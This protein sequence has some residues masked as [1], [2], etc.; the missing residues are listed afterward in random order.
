MET[1]TAILVSGAPRSFQ[2]NLWPFIKSL[3]PNFAFFFSF[4]HEGDTK[5]KNK[6]L[7]YEIILQDPRTK[8]CILESNVPPF[9]TSL[10]QRE[11]N[12][13]IQWYRLKNLI[14]HVSSEYTRIIRIRPDVKFEISVSEFVKLIDTH[15]LP[16]TISIPSGYDIFDPAAVSAATLRYCV[17][18]QIAFGERGP[19]MY[20]CNLYVALDYSALIISENQ[21]YNHL[22]IYKIQRV[23][24]PYNLVLSDCFVVSLC[25]DS[26]A[27]KTSISQLIN[28]VLPYDKS[29]VFETD[30]Y[31]KW[32]RGDSN[33]LV[34]SHLHP[35]ANRLDVMSDDVYKLVLG[36][37][38]YTV[39]YDHA[40]GKFTKDNKVESNDVMI[41]CG[42]HTLYE[43]SLRDISDLKVYVDTEATLKTHWKI[44]RDVLARGATIEH[45][46]KTIE[47]RL[48][49]YKEYVEPQ[50][51]YADV[52]I[53]YYPL[54]E[55]CSNIGLIIQL[56]KEFGFPLLDKMA[57]IYTDLE[58]CAD[59]VL[60]RFENVQSHAVKEAFAALRLPITIDL[61]SGFEG[62]IQYIFTLL[63]WN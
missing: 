20:Y 25:G 2:K 48:G 22:S 21:L 3:P 19:M 24:M 52:L 58:I 62:I 33:Y 12:T 26:G 8:V 10:T 18:D 34:Y 36:K 51:E 5:Y 38:I 23:N 11:K 27:G 31:H 13:V 40:T 37:D 55:D 16:N 41:I 15:T 42:L 4:S 53:R 63:L 45:V 56:N 30:R 29:F 59:H 35:L 46:K 60:F 50:K 43:K 39:D 54:N 6:R 57:K 7:D 28:S 9:P 32:E 44:T 14:S 1:A 61:K 17:N 47:H 49:D